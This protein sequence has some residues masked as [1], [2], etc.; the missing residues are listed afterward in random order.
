M[1]YKREDIAKNKA[2]FTVVVDK[3]VI[4]QH[5]TAAVKRLGKDAKVPGFRR[6]HVPLEVLERA[7][8]PARLGSLEIDGQLINRWWR[9]L[10]RKICNY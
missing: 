8:D 2:K 5:H 9:L 10:L 1:N 6:G 3:E 7:I 4:Q